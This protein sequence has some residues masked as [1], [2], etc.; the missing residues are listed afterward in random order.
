MKQELPVESLN[1]CIGELQR[2]TQEQRLA[3][4]DAQYRFVE[5]RREEVR[6]LEELSNERKKFSEILKSEI[7]TKWEKMK[8]RVDEVSVQ[9]FR[10]NN[11][12]IQKLTSQLQQM[13]EQM[14]S[15]ND[16]EN[17]QDVESN[18]SG[19]L[20]YVTSQ[21]AA[22]PSSRSMLSRD[23]RL[24]LDTWNQSGLQEDVFGSQFST[25]DSPRDHP[26]RIQSDYVQR[27]GEA[28][29]EAGRTKTIHTSEDRQNLG[30]IPMPTFA[31]KPLTTSSTML[32]E[33]QQNCM[34]G[35]QR[36]QISE[37]QYYVF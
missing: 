31:T 37:L 20:S 23:K 22:I 35:Q 4:Q 3:L 33:L 29:P 36:Q 5:S 1:K 6:R 15:M 21:P 11:E 13:Q 10:E 18:Y 9:K 30:T 7:C 19:R 24:P 25:S 12:T 26:Q 17:F 2:Q 32:V 16:S 14:N 34:V 28:V 8:I 27:N